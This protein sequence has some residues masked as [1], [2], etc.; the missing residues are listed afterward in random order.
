MWVSV[1]VGWASAV[2]GSV[3]SGAEGVAVVMEWLVAITL[4]AGLLVFLR[5]RAH[6]AARA[7]NRQV[8][9]LREEWYAGERQAVRDRQARHDR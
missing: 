2:C 7:N 4:L 8:Y 1:G 5:W 6:T 3:G 9:Q